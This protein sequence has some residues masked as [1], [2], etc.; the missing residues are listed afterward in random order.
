MSAVKKKNIGVFLIVL[1][2][3]KNEPCGILEPYNIFIFSRIL[4]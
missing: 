2:I 4:T 1:N 3:Y